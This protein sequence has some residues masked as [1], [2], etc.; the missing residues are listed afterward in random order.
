MSESQ[1]SSP[2]PTTESVETQEQSIASRPEYVP[3]KFWDADKGEARLQTFGESYTQLEQ[4]FHSKMDDLRA[5]VKAESLANRPENASDYTLPE[6]EGVEF[7]EDDPLLSFWR[8]QAHGMGMDNDGF[9]AGIKSYVEAMQAT[10]PNVDQELAKLGED[11]QTRIDAI[12]AW[13]DAKLTEDTK[14][15]LNSL[16]TTAE[17]VVAIEEMMSLS[18]TSSNTV[19]ASQSTPVAETLEELQAL[20]N[21]PRYWGAAGVRDDQLVDRV[22]KG[23]ERLQN[24]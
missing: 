12:N 10:A 4:K 22:T 2:E 14:N 20:M 13:A 11:G 3:E 17:G 19:D 5:E 18:Q 15:A 8:E 1:T 6:L 16:A 23:F 7:Q 24:G 21:D 9:Q